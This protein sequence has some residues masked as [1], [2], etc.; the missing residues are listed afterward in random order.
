M[1]LCSF[2]NRYYEP[3]TS[4]TLRLCQV[5]LNFH[6]KIVHNTFN[7]LADNKSA[8]TIEI[9]DKIYCT[10]RFHYIEQ[11]ST[12]TVARIVRSIKVPTFSEFNPIFGP[13]FLCAL[14][15]VENV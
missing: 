7:V 8:F 12:E 9:L 14:S 1:T 5:S 6:S 11:F 15:E 13:L 2:F 3:V 10:I 4:I